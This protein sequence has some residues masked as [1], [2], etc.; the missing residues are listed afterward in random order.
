MTDRG[1]KLKFFLLRSQR[2][3]YSNELTEALEQKMTFDFFAKIKGLA[4][5][6][7]YTLPRR[8]CL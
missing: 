4:M 7:C 2:R 5:L 3:P 1:S 6:H 8:P